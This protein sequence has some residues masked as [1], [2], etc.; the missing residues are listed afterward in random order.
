MLKWLA[1]TVAF[2]LVLTGCGS[3]MRN[4]TSPSP[5]NNKQVRTQ[6]VAKQPRQMMNDTKSI[7]AHLEAL[8][9]KVPGVKGANCVVLGNTAVVGV[10]VDG[11]LDRAR[12][13]TLK[14]SV[15]EALRKDPHGANAIVTADID[16][17]QRIKD[18]RADINKGRP[19]AGFAEEMA[20]I[21]GR[22][23]PQ[24]PHNTSPDGSPQNQSAQPRAGTARPTS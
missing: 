5:P 9:Q 12:V 16:L 18:M 24:L 8:A 4:G 13:G 21:I 6:Q 2:S 7:A 3:D 11:N 22:I 19:V 1:W 10:D 17:T 14:Y 23:V 20:D 15:A